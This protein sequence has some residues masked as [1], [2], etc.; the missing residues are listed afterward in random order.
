MVEEGSRL[1]ATKFGKRISEL[2]ID[3]LSAKIIR[4]GLMGAPEDLVGKKVGIL[5]LIS[6][7]PDMP[8]L[9]WRRRDE[10]FVT[11]FVDQHE[12]EFL[13]EPPDIGS[14]DYE[15]FMLQVKVAMLLYSWIE[16]YSEDQI[17]SA[18]RVGSGDILRIGETGRWLLYS[19]EEIAK[20]CQLKKAK[21][22]IRELTLRVNHG[23]KKE[24]V[25]L[26]SIPGIGRIRARALY[27]SGYK[28]LRS[29]QRAKIGDLIKV[30]MI[31]K[32][33][34]KKIKETIGEKEVTVESREPEDLGYKADSMSQRS[35]KQ[36][37]LL[38]FSDKNSK[39]TGQKR[40]DRRKRRKRS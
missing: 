24:L 26:V 6:A 17:I 4:D 38:H 12:E 37:K 25:K 14:I 28:S 18:F 19:T 13:Q 30:P 16:E 36:A 5:H 23:I 3:P 8:K 31:G 15:F 29:L 20:L 9:G 7:T 39:K 11:S 40:N 33:I 34:A 35:V 22:T 10:E 21:K 2:Y 32:E 27:N 1:K